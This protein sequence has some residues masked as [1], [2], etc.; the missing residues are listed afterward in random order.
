M[1]KDKGRK[2]RDKVSAKLRRQHQ[3][4]IKEAKRTRRDGCDD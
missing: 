2:D 3:R 1:C 4:E